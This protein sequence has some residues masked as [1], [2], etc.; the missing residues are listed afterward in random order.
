MKRVVIIGG[1]YGGLKAAQWLANQAGIEVV[2][3]DKNKY[4]Y[5]QTDAYDFIANKSDISD[6]ALSLESFIAGLGNNLKFINDEV[7]MIQSETKTIILQNSST[8]TYDYVIVATGALTNFPTQII[9]IKEYSNGVKTLLRALEFKQKFEN[10]IFEFLKKS[11]LNSTLKFNIV[12]GGAGLSGIEIAAEMAYIVGQYCKSIGL[13]NDSI[14][15]TLVEG[16]SSV[17]PGIHTNIVALSQKRLDE[18]GVVVKLNSFISEVNNETIILA[19]GE[20]IA[21]DFMIFTGGIKAQ[22]IAFDFQASM[23][24]YAQYMVNEYFQVDNYPD[25]FAIGDV[26]QISVRNEI[27]PSTAQS[28]EQAGIFCAK[29][30]LNHLKN[31]P[32]K[33]YEPKIYGMFVALGGKYGVG[34]LLNTAIIKGYKAYLLKKLITVGY[35]LII[36]YKVNKGFKKLKKRS[37]LG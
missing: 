20:M 9:G 27:V 12:I 32:M 24:R 8:M 4:H 33:K 7:K 29:N 19:N 1:G 10:T 15:I 14:T 25:I 22:P 3:I 35:K 13:Q 21:Y 5:L 34:V 28:A 31:K 37:L 18:L 26:A 17:L 2:L 16:S 30:I 11:A 6:I 36:W 23:N